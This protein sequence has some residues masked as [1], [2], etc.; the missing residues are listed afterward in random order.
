MNI[1]LNQNK[2]DIKMERTRL[3]K[4]LAVLLAGSMALI[5][6]SALAKKKEKATP[7]KAPTTVEEEVKIPSIE[8][9]C[10]PEECIAFLKQNN[11]QIV[12]GDI[13]LEDSIQYD[14]YCTFVQAEY[15]QIGLELTLPE[16]K[17][18]GVYSNL[19]AIANTKLAEELYNDG[20]VT[21][22][23]FYSAGEYSNIYGKV[24]DF[25]KKNFKNMKKFPVEILT[26]LNF[27]LKSRQCLTQMG[28][29]TNNYLKVKDKVKNQD[30]Y[31]PGFKD[32]YDFLNDADSNFLY[33]LSDL[34]L[35]GQLNQ[36]NAAYL[37]ET[38]VLFTNGVL[39]FNLDC[40]LMG[41][42]SAYTTGKQIEA[43]YPQ[44]NEW[45]SQEK[46]L[47]SK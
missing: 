30:Q 26:L 47:N 8:D 42:D 7:T 15:K 1:G 16:I 36:I 31:L 20:S 17:F 25:L 32:I 28:A 21:A 46:V 44:G 27:N 9:L 45:Y 5:T 12:D 18:L 33:R 3:Q 10:L 23:P 38:T 4:I 41:T 22:P 35:S 34:D 24:Y 29:Y 2:G 37:V 43:L 13:I 39:D 40:Y 11:I 6:S 14:K 19:T